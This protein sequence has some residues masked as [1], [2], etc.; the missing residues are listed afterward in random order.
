MKPLYVLT[1]S[2]FGVTA[3]SFFIGSNAL[4]ATETSSSVIVE[5]AISPTS[6]SPL[7]FQPSVEAKDDHLVVTVEGVGSSRTDA[8]NQAW[9]EAIRLGVGMM[10]EARTEIDQNEVAEQIIAHSRGVIDKYEILM[11]DESKA[12]Q[13]LYRIRMQANVQS[14]VLRDS[15]Q[16]VA[17]GS[18]VIAFSPSDLKPEA[19]LSPEQVE[20]ADASTITAEQRIADAA[21]LL[22]TTIQKFRPIDFLIIKAVSSLRSAEGSDDLF[23]MDFEISFNE[24]LYYEAYLPEMKKV[25][26]QIS[27][28]VETKYFRDSSALTAI[29]NISD[30]GVLRANNSSSVY[31]ELI[32]LRE[33]EIPLF[34]DSNRF[35]YRLYA[36]DFSTASKVRTLLADSEDTQPT[37]VAA[38]YDESEDE[39]FTVDGDI[40]ATVS[41]I[42]SAE[43]GIITFPTTGYQGSPLGPQVMLKRGDRIGVTAALVMSGEYKFT[44]VLKDSTE[45]WVKTQTL[46]KNFRQE[47]VMMDLPLIL[48]PSILLAKTDGLI[49]GLKFTHTAEFTVPREII[50]ELKTIK[51][52]IGH[53]GG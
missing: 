11:A 17:S 49:E 50:D 47:G 35:K 36:L 51:I 23:E 3:F 24:R 34:D 32:N 12:D 33:L 26:D 25:L 43:N 22:A 29:R 4:H 7:P 21:N 19:G 30:Q 27:D 52:S 9:L 2:V 41:S 14:D 42:M 37:F 53:E 1:A 13:G 28:S 6:V 48:L 18:Q 40:P 5:Q 45:I 44:K 39:I 46:D 8:L 16:F 31:I 10:I 20:G 15:L 38:F